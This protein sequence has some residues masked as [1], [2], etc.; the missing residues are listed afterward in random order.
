MD[1]VVLAKGI[2]IEDIKIEVVKSRLESKSV[3]NIQVF[4]GFANFY[5]WFIQSFSRIASLLISML[6]ISLTQWAG[7]L[8]PSVDVVDNIKFSIDGGGDNMVE[9][10]PFY[11]KTIIRDTGYLTPDTKMVFT[12]LKKAFTKA[13]IFCH[14]DP[15]CYIRIKINASGYAIEGVL[16]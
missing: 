2:K 10:L 9:K 11:T 5:P 1:Y 12:Q 16:S 13:L 8:L 14:F 15:E 4:F 6:K 3:K 7:P